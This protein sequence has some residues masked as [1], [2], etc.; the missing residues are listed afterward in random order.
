MDSVNYAQARFEEVRAMPVLVESVV[1]CIVSG[2]LR[3]A[4]RAQEGGAR[5]RGH[6]QGLSGQTL[7]TPSSVG[8]QSYLARTFPSSPSR[9]TW[10][11]TSLQT[12]G[13][14]RTSL[15]GTT[16]L[17]WWRQLVGNAVAGRAFAR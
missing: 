9:P 11:L 8:S 4:L 15:R 5:W 1:E 6:H 2:C 12:E 13:P 17:P 16:D 3:A 10:A 14:R 7:R